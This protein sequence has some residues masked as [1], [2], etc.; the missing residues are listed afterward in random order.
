MKEIETEVHE[1]KSLRLP[2]EGILSLINR[3]QIEE[4]LRQKETQKKIAQE[5]ERLALE[6]KRVIRLEIDEARKV[7]TELAEQVGNAYQFFIGGGAFAEAVQDDPNGD[8]MQAYN[9]TLQL[10]LCHLQNGNVK[11]NEGSYYKE[12]PL[13][14]CI[15][16]SRLSAIN[17]LS[18]LVNPR[19]QDDGNELRALSLQEIG[20][21]AIEI[22]AVVLL[23]KKPINNN[24]YFTIDHRY[25]SIGNE[26]SKEEQID[27]NSQINR[28]L[29]TQRQ[30]LAKVRGA[31]KS[32]SQQATVSKLK[33]ALCS[34]GIYLATILKSRNENK[35]TEYPGGKILLCFDKIRR[36][37]SIGGEYSHP[38][39]EGIE[40][41]CKFIKEIHTEGAEIS[42]DDV[43]E[44]IKEDLDRPKG[45]RSPK[46]FSLWCLVR[47]HIKWLREYREEE[48]F[49]Y[50][51]QKREDLSAQE[52]IN[53]KLGTFV[54][55]LEEFT[56]KE[57]IVSPVA[58]RVERLLVGDTKALLIIETS[59]NLVNAFSYF[60]ETENEEKKIYPEN[61]LPGMLGQF[62][63]RWKRIY[64][65]K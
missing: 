32:L 10:L 49:I 39:A 64:S 7:A 5:Q 20:K 25:F 11:N 14:H 36:T 37:V 50:L 22:N 28:I 29:S 27:F 58:I 23:P 47:S 31:M 3:E 42:F 12:K 30:T 65:I 21:L 55:C 59:P 18:K 6:K 35:N 43:Q 34:G 48:G 17:A 45:K 52:F 4:Q 24:R 33:I 16:P 44:L 13:P 51:M 57:N 41:F 40:S 38:F 8:V 56:L 60:F 62:V 54:L 63:N 2:R 9:S 15:I 19:L 26:L 53:G 61:N 46:D 1:I